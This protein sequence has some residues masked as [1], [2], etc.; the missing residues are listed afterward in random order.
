[1]IENVV[2]S[3]NQA[4]KRQQFDMSYDKQI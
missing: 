3:L 1:M 4:R 2:C